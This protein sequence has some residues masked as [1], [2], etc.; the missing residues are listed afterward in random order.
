M[1]LYIKN[2]KVRDLA[3]E[4]KKLGQERSMTDVIL[5]ALIHEK[6]RLI[7]QKSLTQRVNTVL[8]NRRLRRDVNFASSVRKKR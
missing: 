1:A 2:E 5:T 3:E 8:A 6:E 4:V 7:S